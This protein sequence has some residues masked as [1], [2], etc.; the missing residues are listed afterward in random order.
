[1]DINWSRVNVLIVQIYEIQTPSE[2]ETILALGVDH[3]GS[4]ILSAREWKD[5]IIYDVV[6]LTQA[7]DRRSSL[8]PLFKTFERPELLLKALEYYRPDIIHFCDS[9]TDGIG[10]RNV[11]HKMVALQEIVKKEFPAISIMR[12]I[13]I[14]LTGFAHR[15][16]TIE[17]ADLFGTVSDYFLTDTLILGNNANLVPPTD[18]QPVDGYIGI[19]GQTCDWDVACLLIETAPIPVI[20]AGGISP[21]NI[22]DGISKVRPAGV[23]SCTGTN[24]TDEY[25]N[26]VRFKKDPDKVKQL[27][28]AVRR[29]TR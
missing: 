6:R 18:E 9:L 25:G 22:E 20:L 24:A 23:D 10:I 15:V 5:P 17:L 3:I 2:A 12:S 27:V 21:D 19:T 16:P 8:I 4:V 11:C 13:P 29:F 28:E 14:A 1:M 26:P 7:A